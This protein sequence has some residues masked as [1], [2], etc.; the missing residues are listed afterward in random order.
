MNYTSS[1]ALEMAVKTAAKN[2]PLDT[3]RAISGFYFHRLL[4]RIFSEPSTPFVLKGG[5]GMLART[6]DAR[7]TRDIDLTTSTLNIEN[8]IDELKRLAG[9]NLNDFVSFV[10]LDWHPIK[11]E[12]KYREGYSVSFDTY[13]GS[14]KIQTVSVDLVADQLDCGIPDRLEPADRIVVRGLEEYDYLVYPAEKAVS[15]KVCG[16]MERHNG[17]PSSRVK[18]LVDLA[19][20]MRTVSFDYHTLAITLGT[21]IKVRGLEE[22]IKRFAIPKEWGEA[23]ARQFTNLASKINLPKQLSTMKLA[24]Q[25][26]AHLIDPCFSEKDGLS[27]WSIDDLSWR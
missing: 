25:M 9:K 1:K 20:Y 2:S 8:A 6:T 10:F 21:E 15:D 22:R 14:K 11:A 26:A 18:D 16:I 23:Q 24:E 27:T 4:C 12:D 17:R 3:N 5:L 7:Y 19:I 13:L